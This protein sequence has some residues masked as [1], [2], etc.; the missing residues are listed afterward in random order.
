MGILKK[1]IAG[2]LSLM[3][4]L[5]FG[6][7]LSETEQE[8]N[9]QI[10]QTKNKWAPDQR[11]ALFDI[12]A[13]INQKTILI[14]GET[15]LPEAKKEL[16]NNINHFT[17]TIIDSIS[18]LP[19]NQFGLINLSVANLRATPSHSA[20]LVTQALMGTPVKILKEKNGWY[21]VQTPDLYISWVD[22]AGISP[23]SVKQHNNWRNSLRVI[24]TSE[25]EFVR[26]SNSETSEI[27]SDLTPGGIVEVIADKNDWLL[28]ILPDG[29]K[30]FISEINCIDFDNFKQ[31]VHPEPES[32]VRMAKK[33]M[34]RP[35]L[36]GGTST[37]A[38]DCSGFV[39]S[40]YF[41]HG[42]ILARDASLQTRHGQLIQPSNKHDNFTKGDLLFFGR[43]SAHV[44]HVA[45]SLGESEYIH[46][47]GRIKKNSFDPA[48]DNFSEH[49]KNSY[50]RA[51]RI[52]GSEGTAGLIW[53]KEHPW[54]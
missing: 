3:I 1:P 48:K 52:I 44:T 19:D 54:Y 47:A 5:L 50:I 38:M 37:R 6:C 25:N 46:A 23:I 21:L 29:R 16:L 4:L 30:G 22:D 45:F 13:K 49:R 34:G 39:K 2:L 14:T 33:M 42:I 18:L 27:I 12:S 8:I 11:E 36:W 7:S 20:E 17:Q 51:R 43:D 24:I 10:E 41:M 9:F 15:N 35:Y 26:S 31:T 32:M 40:V 28:V 53:V